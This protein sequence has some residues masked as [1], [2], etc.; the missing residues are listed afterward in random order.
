MNRRDLLLA[1]PGLALA[2]AVTDVSAVERE[3][4]EAYI[5]LDSRRA[6]QLLKTL[7]DV[8]QYAFIGG[9][10]VTTML[11][12]DDRRPG[13]IFDYRTARTLFQYRYPNSRRIDLS[14]LSD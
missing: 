1:L 13:D 9:M 6:W 4:F 8:N 7:P 14:S 12:H 11:K 10:G 2:G 3:A 5:N